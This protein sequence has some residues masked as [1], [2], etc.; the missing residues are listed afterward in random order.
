MNLFINEKHT[1]SKY[2]I[3]LEKEY[4]NMVSYLREDIY[5]EQMMTGGIG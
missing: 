3:H 2:V 5:T 4:G 1:V